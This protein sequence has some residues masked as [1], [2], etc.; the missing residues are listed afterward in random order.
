[1]GEAKGH[2]VGKT[3]WMKKGWKLSKEFCGNQASEVLEVGEGE[4]M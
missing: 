2:Q 4:R 3:K 1:M